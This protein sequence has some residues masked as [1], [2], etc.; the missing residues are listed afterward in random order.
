MTRINLLPWREARRQ[1]RQ[2]Q[3]NMLA[4]ATSLMA[5]TGISIAHLWIDQRID[6]QARRNGYLQQ[7]IERLAQLAGQVQLMD[8]TKG[9]LLAEFETIQRLQ[10]SRLHMIRILDCIPRALPEDLFLVSLEA[11]EW[12]IVLKGAAGSHYAVSRLL[13]NLA[14]SSWLGGPS[15]HVIESREFDGTRARAFEVVIDRNPLSSSGETR[16]AM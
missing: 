9:R 1:R 7:Q 11:A 6:D 3:F 14:G 4:L 10:T 5:I 16:E 12:R 8:E 2:K 13:R 15:L